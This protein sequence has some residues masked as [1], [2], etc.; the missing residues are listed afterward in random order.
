MPVPPPLVAVLA[1]V[2]TA[3]ALRAPR[4]R[5]APR[6]PAPSSSP[7]A[8]TRSNKS[9][10]RRLYREVWNNADLASANAS[11]E[12][13]VS[14]DHVLIDPSNPTPEPG[15][16][17]YM[18]HVRGN[19]EALP[20]Y[21]IAV[22]NVIEEGDKC[23]AQL[24]FTASLN[25]RTARWTGTCVMEFENGAIVKSW[26]NTDA[27][28][29][30]IQLGLMTD[31]VHTGSLNSRPVTHALMG[32]DEPHPETVLTGKEWLQYFEEVHESWER[33]SIDSESARS[34]RT[35]KKSGLQVVI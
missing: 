10:V 6:P 26:V 25:E 24:S 17:A 35:D 28:S 20:D 8:P 9:I 7:R 32:R 13:Y 3:L 12:R 22:D 33:R 11:A 19:R 21:V 2:A 1:S 31:L 30:M 29:A 23:V 34:L 27:M 16:E 4:A 14:D 15:V 5:V 18:Q